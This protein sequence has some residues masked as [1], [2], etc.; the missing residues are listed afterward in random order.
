MDLDTFREVLAAYRAPDE[1]CRMPAV[2]LLNSFA[3]SQ[4][5][6]FL[7]LNLENVA[8]PV[9]GDT[10]PAFSSSVLFKAA[11]NGAITSHP[12]FFEPF[13]ARLAAV[14]PIVFENPELPFAVKLTM[15]SVLALMCVQTFQATESTVVHEFVTELFAARPDFEPYI[16]NCLSAVMFMSG[17]PCGFDLESIGGFIARPLTVEESVTPHFCLFFAVAQYAPDSGFLHEALPALLESVPAGCLQRALR[18]IDDFSRDSAHFF[19]PHI[20]LFLEWLTGIARSDAPKAVRNT[21]ILVFPS[22][23]EGAREMAQKCEPFCQEMFHCLIEIAGEITDD[24]P[25]E[26]DPMNEAEPYQ[27]AVDALGEIFRVSGCPEHF[28]CIME[29]V[30]R[31]IVDVGTDWQFIY[32]GLAAVAEFDVNTLGSLYSWSGFR[33]FV[34]FAI[35]TVSDFDSNPRLRRI[36]YELLAHITKDSQQMMTGAFRAIEAFFEGSLVSEPDPRLLLMGFAYFSDFFSMRGL[37]SL[38]ESRAL[39]Y[40]LASNFLPAANAGTLPYIVHVLGACAC[41]T[42][43]D[44][45][46]ET[47]DLLR[48]L[49]GRADLAVRARIEIVLAIAMILMELSHDGQ[50]APLDD[51]VAFALGFLPD[52]WYLRDHCVDD[53]SRDVCEDTILRLIDGAGP[54]IESQFYEEMVRLACDL[55]TKEINIERITKFDEPLAARGMY[56]RVPGSDPGVIQFVRKTDMEEISFGLKVLTATANAV[57]DAFLPFVEH[58]FGIAHSWMVHSLSLDNIQRE[59]WHLADCLIMIVHKVPTLENRFDYYL[60]AIDAFLSA[61]NIVIS[62]FQAERLASFARILR[63]AIRAGWSDEERL[64]RIIGKYTPSFDARISRETDQRVNTELWTDE[65]EELPFTESACEDL[66]PQWRQIMTLLLESFHDLVFPIFEAGIFP[67]F[68]EYSRSDESLPFAM[69]LLYLYFKV[70][71]NDQA[72]VIEAIEWLMNI[73]CQALH[74]LSSDAFFYCRKLFRVYQ[75]PASVVMKFLQMFSDFIDADK[76]DE[77][78]DATALGAMSELIRRHVEILDLD[79]VID[80]WTDL[81]V[82][83]WVDDQSESTFD[84]LDW[85]LERRHPIMLSEEPLYRWLPSVLGPSVDDTLREMP[86]YRQIRRRIKELRAD[87]EIGPTLQA[88]IK[89]F[90]TRQSRFATER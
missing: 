90:I 59:A 82:S 81:F 1:A 84:L 79:T 80:L 10:S 71:N 36:S 68:E 47:V 31:L 8:A 17:G 64:V 69:D 14:L 73:A 89:E 9:P 27:T 75:F 35:R 49:S 78:L 60:S 37:P 21:A 25:W 18:V 3:E 86:I 88:A 51:L 16:M 85:L 11:Q 72:K 26:T 45:L 15:S 43:P 52:I 7:I 46:N 12:E 76:L 53:A 62:R 13:W 2:A 42:G 6:D 70:P 83:T 19:I 48:D 24:A 74:G 40:E 87:P 39:G 28:S 61:D 4:E 55:A 57:R 33:E 56:T 41:A 34:E 63:M 38:Q 22:I 58:V 65:K 66:R 54:A 23:C 44:K 67:R 29:I 30:G 77:V 5:A 20:E 50:Q 32:A